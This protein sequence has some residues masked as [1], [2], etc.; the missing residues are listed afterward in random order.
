MRRAI[1]VKKRQPPAARDWPLDPRC[2]YVTG[3]WPLTYTIKNVLKGRY[4]YHQ[5]KIY[6]SGIPAP[7]R[8]IQGSGKEQINKIS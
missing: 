1:P 2:V 7:G 3:L 6:R 5:K 4:A 8:K